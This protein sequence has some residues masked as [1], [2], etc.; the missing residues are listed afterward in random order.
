MSFFQKAG[1]FAGRA[2]ATAKNYRSAYRDLKSAFTG[3]S[4][5]YYP[6]GKSQKIPVY[7]V[8]RYAERMADLQKYIAELQKTG[9]VYFV[10]QAKNRL[11]Y[12]M[13]KQ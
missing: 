4:G 1:R 12:L 13:F 9:N 3:N 10:Y 5:G 6:A 11:F 8:Y 7:H 2:S